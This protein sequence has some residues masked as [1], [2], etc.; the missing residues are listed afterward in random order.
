M[1]DPL[2]RRFV[3]VYNTNVLQGGIYVHLFTKDD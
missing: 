2:K 3:E 1:A